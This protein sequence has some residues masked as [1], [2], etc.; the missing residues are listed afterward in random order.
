MH[1]FVFINARGSTNDIVLVDNFFKFLNLSFFFIV[2][3]MT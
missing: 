3:M 1:S 2:A